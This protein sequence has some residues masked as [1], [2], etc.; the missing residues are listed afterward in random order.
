MRLETAEIDR[1]GPLKGCR[2]PCDD[3]ITVI[4]G[5]NESGK[6]LYLEGMLQ[7]LDPAVSTQMDPPP[8]V[9]QH[10]TGRVVIGGGSEQHVLGDGTALSDVS[11]VE[12]NHLYNLFV[13]RDSDLALPDGPDYYTS[14][15]EHLGDIHTSEIEA[16]RKRLVKRGLLTPTH[17]NLRNR[18]HDTK[19]VRNAAET[20]AEDVESYLESVAER[21]VREK[22]RERLQVKKQ[23]ETVETNL[24]TQRTAE[25]VANFED[26]TE[27]LRQYSNATERI[28]NLEDFDRKTL[29]NLRDWNQTL[30]HKDDRIDELESSL[31]DKK[32]EVQ[33]HRDALDEARNRH[34]T[35][36]QRESAVD[37]VESVL[38]SYR[39]QLD[40]SGGE[41]FESRLLHRRYAT[42]AGLAGAGVAA[43]SGVFI[44]TVLA[45]VMGIV[46][47]LVAIGAWISHRRLRD[48]VAER[49]ELER[50][51]LQTARDAGFDVEVPDDV[52]PRLGEYREKLDA[53]QTRIHELETKLQG[54]TDRVEELQEEL[55]GVESDR[56]RVEAK[57]TSTLEEA[58][59]DSVEEYEAH[60][61]EKEAQEHS[62]SEAE[63]VLFR[64]IGDPDVES[65]ERKIDYWESE[66]DDWKSDLGEIHVDAHQYDET[67]L[68]RLEQRREK[69]DS[70]IEELE[71][72]LQDYHDKLDEFE[73]RANNLTPP[74]FVETDPVLQ[75][76][77]TEGLRNLVEKLHALVESIE[78][79]AEI[80]RKGISILD[81]IK[82]DEEQKVAT[83]FDPDGPASRILSRLTDGR[84]TT[85]NYDP[86][87]E[88]LE[89]ATPDGRT[90]TPHQLSRGTQDQLYFAARLSLARQL[91]GGD[92]GFLLLDDP[93][94][95]AD[96]TRLRNGFETLTGLAD[97]GWQILYL[98]AKNEVWGRMADE[99]ECTVHELEI[100]EH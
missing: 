75:A 94:L 78:R 46:L 31:E 11:R 21:G 79:N 28:Q 22:T 37:S 10:P 98:T 49:E 48:R 42:A 27:Q 3:G 13:I 64:E 39:T 73:R 33:S 14:L 51:L 35:L 34:T 68:E 92:S 88:A 25:E 57:L 55:E 82:D 95:A 12:P 93:F 66:L 32:A 69:L 62:R 9:Q 67:A 65:P 2:P 100:I 40:A 97:D 96:Q 89:V 63:T 70:R 85:V 8:R 5:P 47:L 91:L 87:T 83:L 58:D 24:A 41:S 52:A 86:D 36:Q 44:G 4:A 72:E 61:E 7:L 71:G 6:T 43:G 30:S 26:A 90:L 1:Y 99:F 76:R 74:Q 15:V 77:T 54:A 18:E 81:A 16:V 53:A 17:L 23:L 80:S 50:E 60:V 59:V 20:L 56:D 38:E 29:E 84:Y 19:D 45:I